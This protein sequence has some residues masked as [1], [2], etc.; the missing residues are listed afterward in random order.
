[1]ELIYS[2]ETLSKDQNTRTQSYMGLHQAITT[3]WTGQVEPL[4]NRITVEV[5]YYPKITEIA[6]GLNIVEPLFSMPVFDRMSIVANYL[7]GPAIAGGSTVQNFIPLP[8]SAKS[9]WIF[10]HS[11]TKVIL[12]VM[13]TSSSI[14]QGT[15]GFYV[16][17]NFN[18]LLTSDSRFPGLPDVANALAVLNLATDRNV[19]LEL[20][21]DEIYPSIDYANID[22]SVQQFTRCI[23]AY[24]L[25]PI[26]TTTDTPTSV[27]FTFLFGTH[28]P[29]GTGLINAPNLTLMSKCNSLPV[30]EPIGP[31]VATGTLLNKFMDYVAK[32]LNKKKYFDGVPPLPSDW[33]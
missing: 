26:L 5:P 30:S 6:T 31:Q 19:T 28:T 3:S 13:I 24:P 25:T 8:L 21:Y 2:K 18:R 12:T 17:K 10:R 14:V 27:F 4:N 15:V 22:N 23:A 32:G 11:S 29:T 1:M 20:D 9:N 7:K 16:V 33:A